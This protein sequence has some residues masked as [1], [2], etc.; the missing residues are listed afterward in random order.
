M[1]LDLQFP[2]L[3]HRNIICILCR[4]SAPEDSSLFERKPVVKTV[5]P[6]WCFTFTEH[7]LESRLH[8][9]CLELHRHLSG[10]PS[11]IYPDRSSSESSGSCACSK[12]VNTERC[13]AAHHEHHPYWY[14][15]FA[16]LLDH[17]LHLFIMG[18]SSLTSVVVSQPGDTLAVSLNCFLSLRFQVMR[19]SDNWSGRDAMTSPPTARLFRPLSSNLYFVFCS[20]HFDCRVQRIH[21]RDDIPGGRPVEKGI[22]DTAVGSNQ[23][24]DEAVHVQP[25][26]T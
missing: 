12:S 20:V 8:P 9:H 22:W 24:M 1:V 10:D 15:S 7:G 18:C 14:F 17:E 6:E 19:P 26:T 25:V 3:R 5:S 13:G 11:V 4:G 23:A 16:V 2:V 21:R